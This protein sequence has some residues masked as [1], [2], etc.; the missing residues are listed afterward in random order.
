M[1]RCKALGDTPV[2]LCLWWCDEPAGPPWNTMPA[3]F[4]SAGYLA[5]CPRGYDDRKG[6]E[7][8]CNRMNL[9]GRW[10]PKFRRVLE[11][12]RFLIIWKVVGFKNI[13]S[14]HWRGVTLLSIPRL[15]AKDEHLTVSLIH[16]SI[17]VSVNI[18]RL[19]GCSSGELTYTLS[20]V[21]TNLSPPQRLS[22]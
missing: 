8:C 5:R 10:L 15:V 12:N 4:V 13:S 6:C 1:S 20:S 17:W 3:G 14:L 9:R 11:Q 19:L 18:R 2:A 16:F 21:W 22:I 7:A